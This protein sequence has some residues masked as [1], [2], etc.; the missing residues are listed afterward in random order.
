LER[1]EL[2]TTNVGVEVKFYSNVGPSLD[3]VITA[4]EKECQPIHKELLRAAIGPIN[5]GDIPR[6]L[7]HL[8]TRSVC[9]REDL[10]EMNKA[11]HSS[12][13]EMLNEEG[14]TTMLR[15]GMIAKKEP[16][17][18]TA[19]RKL[20]HNSMPRVRAELVERE[21][22]LQKKA[23]KWHNDSIE[24]CPIPSG[25]VDEYAKF[26]YQILGCDKEPFVLGDGALF[27][28]QG[29]HISGTNFPFSALEEVWLP[30]SPS[31][32]LAGARGNT[33]SPASFVPRYAAMSAKT[34][35]VSNSNGQSELAS[36]I[37]TGIHPLLA[38][39][40]DQI[41]RDIHKT[42]GKS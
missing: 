37:G 9:I 30:L 21:K 4:M 17:N 42:L 25:K 41:V 31:R 1:K 27:F 40:R 29:T 7:T 11:L 39:I 15:A 19:L 8:E 22:G 24:Q 38:E 23:K 5:L 16:I 20:A 32:C 34:F 2:S 33:V 36:H 12:L 13:A 35:F 28:R 10:T 18:E 6:L 14:I 26:K 3:D